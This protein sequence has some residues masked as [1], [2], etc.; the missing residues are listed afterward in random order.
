MIKDFEGVVQKAFG[1]RLTPLQMQHLIRYVSL[2]KEWSVRVRLISK[3][4][5]DYIWE[6]HIIDC[7]AVVPFVPSSGTLLDF[8]SGAGLP[9]IP[10]AIALPNVDVHLLEPARMKTLFLNHVVQDL[11]LTNVKIVRARSEELAQN[12]EYREQYEYIVA[13]AV[14]ALPN[15]W[16]LVSPLLSS[17]GQLVSLKGPN[18]G[19]ELVGLSQKN[20]QMEIKTFTLPLS[21]K[22]RAVATLRHVSRET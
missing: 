2:L 3:G 8:G 12:D 15:L 19:E 13:R 22:E 5:R 10:I 4:D 20:L 7:L 18:V 21:H 1:I 6:R 11:G 17:S 14:S 16:K 9:G